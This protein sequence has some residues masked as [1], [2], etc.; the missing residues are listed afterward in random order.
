[1]DPE[2]DTR[3]LANSE[4][5]ATGNS[6]LRSDDDIIPKDSGDI[7]DERKHHLS[8][9]GE[10]D[11]LSER[12]NH[13]TPDP[14]DDPRTDDLP[15]VGK[16]E[17]GKRLPPTKHGTH[18]QRAIAASALDAPPD[19]DDGDDIDGADSGDIFDER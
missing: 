5:E 10:G 14:D 7:W 18:Q 2:N 16:D 6:Y 9:Y 8:G 19:G 3:G 11:V 1:M 17:Q 13:V 15:D 12:L 4:W